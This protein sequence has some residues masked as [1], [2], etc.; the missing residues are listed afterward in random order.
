MQVEHTDVLKKLCKIK[1]IS[2]ILVFMQMQ[3]SVLHGRH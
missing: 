2:F 3:Y 1:F